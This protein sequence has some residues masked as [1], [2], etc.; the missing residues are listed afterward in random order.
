VVPY[1]ALNYSLSSWNL[2]VNAVA[3]A[4]KLY[5]SATYTGIESIKRYSEATKSSWSGVEEWFDRL[6]MT[7]DF[8][9]VI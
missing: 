4:R 7:V 2:Q 6:T 9:L 8:I 3:E 1:I 5:P